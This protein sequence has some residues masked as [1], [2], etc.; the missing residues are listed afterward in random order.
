MDSEPV[1]ESQSAL[2]APS[3]SMVSVARAE[4]PAMLYVQA[5]VSRRTLQAHLA[6]AAQVP[7]EMPPQGAQR[8]SSRRLHRARLERPQVALPVSAQARKVTTGSVRVPSARCGSPLRAL[9]PSARAAKR[10][11]SRFGLAQVRPAQPRRRV[12]LVLP[13][14][15][16][17]ALRLQRDSSIQ[18]HFAPARTRRLLRWR[19]QLPVQ[20]VAGTRRP[21]A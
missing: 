18:R 7:V 12:A 1:P 4:Q 11:V 15:Q 14:A 10:R 17:A 9:M 16:R 13:M 6:P 21:E 3:M 8:G 2:Q 19:A 20:R 5:Q